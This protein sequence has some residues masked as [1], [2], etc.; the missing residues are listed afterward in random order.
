MELKVEGGVGVWYSFGSWGCL[1]V[2][3]VGCSVSF[4]EKGVVGYVVD[5]VVD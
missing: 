2:W 3:V 5:Y 4:E 1:G